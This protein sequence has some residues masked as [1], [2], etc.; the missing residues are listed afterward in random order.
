MAIFVKLPICLFL[1]LDGLCVIGAC[2]VAH[3]DVSTF[4]FFAS[5]K[6]NKVHTSVQVMFIAFNFGK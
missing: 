1:P 2:N 5:E 3:I 6:Q 4:N